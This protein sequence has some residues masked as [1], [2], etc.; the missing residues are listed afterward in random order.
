MHLQSVFLMIPAIVGF[1][2]VLYYLVLAPK[3]DFYRKQKLT[4]VENDSDVCN[5]IRTRLL[6]DS[7]VSNLEL[8]RE[9][10]EAFGEKYPAM[11]LNDWRHIIEAYT[12]MVKHALES[13][14]KEISM[15]QRPLGMAAESG[16][17]DK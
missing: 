8:Q 17:E 15:Q 1:L 13:R 12:P 4:N 9:V 3:S 14:A 16:V 5:L 2:G 7:T 6:M 11:S 10:L